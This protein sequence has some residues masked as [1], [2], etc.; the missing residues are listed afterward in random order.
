TSPARI[1]TTPT[2]SM[3]TTV[4]VASLPRPV[5][6]FRPVASG[7]PAGL[8]RRR[9]GPLLG[10][11]YAHPTPIP[12][13]RYTPCC[14]R[15]NTAS[16]LRVYSERMLPYCYA[17]YVVRVAAMV[18]RSPLVPEARSPTAVRS[19]THDRAEAGTLRHSATTCG[20]G[21]EPGSADT[22]CCDCL[23]DLGRLCPAHGVPADRKSTRLN[24]SH[25]I[26]SYAVFCLKK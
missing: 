19:R 24:S 9:R 15:R 23:R 8:T 26:I 1:T 5:R 3:T 13:S 6:L 4:T 21:R 10:Y 12:A 20:N 17:F 16:T 14:Q 7:L 11:G 22:A 18:G 25:Q 2:R